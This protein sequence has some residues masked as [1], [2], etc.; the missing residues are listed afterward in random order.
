MGMM[1]EDLVDQ[2]ALAAKVVIEL[3]LPRLRRFHDLLGARRLNA[4]LVKE[5]GGGVDDSPSRSLSLH[6]R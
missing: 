1:L 5:V 2:P 3:A 6:R 4:L